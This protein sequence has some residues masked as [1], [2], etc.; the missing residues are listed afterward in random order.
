MAR[1]ALKADRPDL[2]FSTGGYSAGPVVAAARDLGIPYIVHSAD[3]VPP[4]SSA[5]FAKEAFAFTTVFRATS[6]FFTE[7]EVV[8]TGQPIRRELRAAAE[9]PRPDHE[10]TVLVVG[11]SQGSE[12]LN[13]VMPKA[14][15]TGRFRARVI[16]ATGPAHIDR[17][18]AR[19]AE[20]KLGPE[21][22]TYP[23]LET[24]AML[25]AYRHADVVVARSGGTV[26]EIAMFGLPSVLV[27]LPFSANDH[28]LEN[29]R[30]FEGMNAATVL[31]QPE[32]RRQPAPPATPEGVADAIAA[33]LSDAPKREAA[34]HNLHEW[35]IP[36]ATERIVR[37]IESVPIR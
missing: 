4:R 34:R 3:S 18:R 15:A 20:A 8:R 12:F 32:D 19:V 23:Y 14:A 31:W 35:D 13:T 26:A 29:A 25:D 7:R 33:W 11:G 5:M 36:D 2:V 28:Q 9:A 1:R 6:R 21:Y 27:P 17:S 24:E 16:H 30:E 10:P 22:E 37:L